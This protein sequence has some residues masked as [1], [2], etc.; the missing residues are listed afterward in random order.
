MLRVL[1]IEN[2]ALI[3]SLNIQ[4]DD[5]Y[6]V[7]TGETGAGKSIIMGALALILGN[8]ADSSVLFDKSRKC[9]VEAEFDIVRLPIKTFFEE[10]NLD[11]HDITI[12]RR[13]ITENGKSRA[14]IN[15]TPVNLQTLKELT[16]KLID[17]HS[18]HQNLLFQVADFRVQ[19]LDQFAQIQ[20]DLSEYQSYLSDFKRYDND[21][22]TLLQKQKSQL[23]KKDFLEFV[24]NELTDAKL[25]ENEQEEAE[26]KIDF[27]THAETIK[28][29]LF[30]S[31]QILSEQESSILDQLREV[32]SL[33]GVIAPYSAEIEQLSKRLES[34]YIEIKD[35]I[36][37]VSALENKAEFD[38]NELE[39]L[40]ERMDLIYSLQLKHH[41]NSVADLLEKKEAISHELCAFSDDEEKIVALKQ[42]KSEAQ[43]KAEAKAKYLSFQRKKIIPVLEKQ[44]TNKIHLLGMTDGQFVVKI[45]EI[46][47]LQKNG[48]DNVQFLFSANKGAAM[49]ELDKVASGGEISRLM[50][51]VKS[52]LSDKT[53]LPTVIFDEIDVGIS[54]EIA[55]KVAHL[56]KEM[57]LSRQLLVI[58]HL[59]QIA[60]HGKVHY[61]VYKE[62]VENKS[63]TKIKKLE[64]DER[65][66][67]IAKMMSGDKWSD[68]A[69]LA[70]QELIAK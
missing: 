20:K 48:I 70:A 40:K 52:T 39:R 24:L 30:Q 16:S 46:D 10:N 62:V 13:E 45:S 54:G 56:M 25:I 15:D 69:L 23:E 6:T 68:A 5:G 19:V 65:A 66:V 51:A 41:V 36:S 32:K 8:R 21:L 7:I 4:F 50:L 67:E 37:D 63:Y 44:V 57:S 49:S 3:S 12:I 60:A 27:L 28:G 61:Q 31:L 9:I 11:Y 14:F 2:Y 17:I 64:K 33:C 1:Q 53:V 29:N 59:P 58:T 42:Q 55:G 26:Q 35:I 18:Q 43:L 47:A 34:N 38:P 22:E